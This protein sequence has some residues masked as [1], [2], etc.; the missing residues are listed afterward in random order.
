[1]GKY[2]LTPSE[3]ARFDRMWNGMAAGK[4]ATAVIDF[5][6]FCSWLRGEDASFYYSIKNKLKELWDE[7]KSTIGDVAEGA[8]LG[9]VGVATAP[10][11]GVYEG[12]KEGFDNGL[13]AGVKKGFKAM[14]DYLDD[15]FS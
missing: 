3:R 13:E 4:K 1:M 6:H 7:I 2:P 11:V 12:I 9:V 15:L 5:D 8:F 14:G 10:I